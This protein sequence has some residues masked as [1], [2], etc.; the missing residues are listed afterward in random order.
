MFSPKFEQIRGHTYHASF[1]PHTQ[2]SPPCVHTT[3]HI[4]IHTLVYSTI[5]TDISSSD[6][7][8]VEVGSVLSSAEELRS[9]VCNRLLEDHR[10]F[11][12]GNGEGRQKKSS[13]NGARGVF[14]FK[15][16]ISCL[17]G[18]G[19][20]QSNKARCYCCRSARVPTM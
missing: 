6:K 19:S 7:R 10:Y 20:E 5:D 16:G 13:W 15:Y 17:N 12:A 1:T 14:P 18:V 8:R 4:D 9:A 3:R 11:K 2:T